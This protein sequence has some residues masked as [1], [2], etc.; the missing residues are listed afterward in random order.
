MDH[1]DRIDL[2]IVGAEGIGADEFGEADRSCA[3]RS[4]RTG[5]I[6]CSTT[7]TPARA[8]LPGG[9]AAGEAAA[10]DVDG[11]VSFDRHAMQ[12]GHT[13]P[14][15]KSAPA[16][17]PNEKA[18]RVDPAG[19]AN[20]N[21]ASKMDRSGAL[22]GALADDGLDIGAA[23]AEVVEFTVGQAGTVRGPNSR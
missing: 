18:R 9:F 1:A 5:R 11:N 21:Y 13:A 6:S 4:P 8:D 22:A 10:D 3:P 17:A 14:A 7:G 15:R 2:G 19:L 16:M 20:A 12:L 23:D